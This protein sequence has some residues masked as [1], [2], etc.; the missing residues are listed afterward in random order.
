MAARVG[1]E[2]TFAVLVAASSPSFAM[3]QR[4]ITPSYISQLSSSA[5]YRG[6]RAGPGRLESTMNDA[7]THLAERFRWQAEWCGRLGS[8]LYAVLLVPAADDLASGG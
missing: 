1:S 3:A 4:D 7:R 5:K 8:K 6:R 2:R